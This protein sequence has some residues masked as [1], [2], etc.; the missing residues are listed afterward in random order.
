MLSKQDAAVMIV[1]ATIEEVQFLMNRVQ[2]EAPTICPGWRLRLHAL[3][4]FNKA[5]GALPKLGNVEMVHLLNYTNFGLPDCISGGKELAIAMSEHHPEAE[6]AFGVQ[7]LRDVMQDFFIERGI[8][9]FH[10]TLSD[11]LRARWKRLHPTRA[12][13][14]LW[15]ASDNSERVATS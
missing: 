4:S 3:A 6:V 10:G 12:K 5:S 15:V 7:L 2:L 13:P 11:A 8:G 14:T 1:G 9:I